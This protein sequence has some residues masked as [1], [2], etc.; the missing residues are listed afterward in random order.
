MFYTGTTGTTAAPCQ[1]ATS[2]LQTA[3]DHHCVRFRLGNL[4]SHQLVVLVARIRCHWAI[5]PHRSSRYTPTMAFA[6]ARRCPSVLRRL[7]FAKRVP[8][9]R[10]NVSFIASGLNRSV[11]SGTRRITQL[12]PIRLKNCYATAAKSSEKSSEKTKAS[13]KKR[14]AKKTTETKAK[15]TVA[16][17][18]NGRGR[19]PLTEEQK[20]EA[21]RK[22]LKRRIKMLKEAAL[23]PPKGLPSRPHRIA[24]P[25]GPLAKGDD[26]YARLSDE[27]KAVSIPSIPPDSFY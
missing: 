16:K 3:I 5:V 27:E 24:F 6:V 8:L 14:T 9:V 25:G 20:E 26:Y 11:P 23:T 17:E 4:F 19:K 15:K 10:R 1:P 13:T 18:K 22:A 2:S 12:L 21:A 7:V